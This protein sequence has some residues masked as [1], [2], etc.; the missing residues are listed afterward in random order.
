MFEWLT[1]P[2]C[3]L[4]MAT[5]Q[6][7]PNAAIMKYLDVYAVK[8]RA[9]RLLALGKLQR[10]SRVCTAHGLTVGRSRVA[11]VQDGPVGPAGADGRV[12]RMPAPAPRI[13]V[14][15]ERSLQAKLHH[16]GLAPL[17]HLGGRRGFR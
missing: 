11:V 3:E 9:G 17:H 5:G 15:Q 2:A 6:I 1:L 16:A 13:A 7:I 10:Q 12:G 4:V 8:P 14:V